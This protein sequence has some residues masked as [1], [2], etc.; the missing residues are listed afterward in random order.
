MKTPAQTRTKETPPAVS[1]LVAAGGNI[2]ATDDASRLTVTCAGIAGD[3]AMSSGKARPPH[4]K[5][6]TVAT[7]E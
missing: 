7:I 4:A 5:R 2:L 6:R 1:D 3:G